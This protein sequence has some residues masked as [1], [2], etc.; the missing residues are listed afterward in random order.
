MPFLSIRIT[1]L[2]SFSYFHLL[3]PKEYKAYYLDAPQD[4]VVAT[5]FPSPLPTHPPTLT[6]FVQPQVLKS[7]VHTNP[8]RQ[9]QQ[10]ILTWIPQIPIIGVGHDYNGINHS[11][12]TRSSRCN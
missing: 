10:F 7:T 9:E 3:Q 1:F 8:Q 4:L 6:S 12:F 5:L 2:L 11:P